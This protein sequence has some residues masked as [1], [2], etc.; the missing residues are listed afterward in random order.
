MQSFQ[1]FLSLKEPLVA[2]LSETCAVTSRTNVAGQGMT[3]PNLLET[4]RLLC[5]YSSVSAL[6]KKP[7]KC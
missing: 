5:S 2:T 6:E 3:I 1:D 7:Q 4:L